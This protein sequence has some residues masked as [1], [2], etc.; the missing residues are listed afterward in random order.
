VLYW[1]TILAGLSGATGSISAQVPLSANESTTG[2][3]RCTV[4]DRYD[5]QFTTSASN[6]E[7]ASCYLITTSNSIPYRLT[8]I[9]SA[10]KWNIR[11]TPFRRPS[12]AL[13]IVA[14][15]FSGSHAKDS[16]GMVGAIAFGPSRGALTTVWVLLAKTL[17]EWTVSEEGWEKVN[18]YVL[19]VYFFLNLCLVSHS[20][21][22]LIT[23]ERNILQIIAQGLVQF[24]GAS[25][26]DQQDLEISMADIVILS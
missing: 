13:S 14:S 4:S 9:Y 26:N 2:L 24:A 18:L 11:V 25:F 7:E 6:I 8:L 21:I 5:R 3:F 10:G 23:E 20:V 16:E 15:I 19:S 12:T 22:Q 1:D 17:Q